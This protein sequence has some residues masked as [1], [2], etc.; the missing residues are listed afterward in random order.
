MFQILSSGV[1]QGS[2]LD[3]ILFNIFVSELFVCLSKTYLPNFP[4]VNAI[5]AAR[6]TIKNLINIFE[7]ESK[8]A[9]NYF[10]ENNMLVNPDR[11]QAIVVKRNNKMLDTYPLNIN[12]E[13]VHSEKN[14]L[15]PTQIIN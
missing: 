12:G 8:L 1:S 10:K 6:K 3:P 2:I 14:Y 7:E 15:E 4:D 9:I 11:F 5:S 13:I